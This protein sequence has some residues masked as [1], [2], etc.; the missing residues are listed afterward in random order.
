MSDVTDEYGRH[1][2]VT[3]DC[4]ATWCRDHPGWHIEPDV[5]E[6]ET[7]NDCGGRYE[8]TIW[9]APDTLWHQL[10]GKPGG[11]LCP[12]CFDDRAKQAGIFL[13]W[14]PHI[15]PPVI[16]PHV[17]LVAALN[18]AT[19]AADRIYNAIDTYMAWREKGE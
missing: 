10:V 8:H 17:E 3:G 4:A 6:G 5:W 7:C 18:N 1:I 14:T 13:R 9:T 15:E 11:T 16:D 12:P 2:H 19:A